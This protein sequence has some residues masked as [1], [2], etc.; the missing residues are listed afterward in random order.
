MDPWSRLT[1]AS[2]AQT[3][4][5]RYYMPCNE[6]SVLSEEHNRMIKRAIHGGRT[7]ARCLLKEWTDEEV[8]AGKYGVYQDVQSLYPTVQF[9]DPL[10]V[11]PPKYRA[12]GPNAQVDFKNF[13]GFACVDI[14]PTKYL[15]HPVL[16]ELKDNK[17]IADLY[18]QYQQVIC[19]PEL[20]VALANGYVVMRVHWT[21]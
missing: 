17:L 6:M 12:Y 2:Y 10:P 1:I 16:V 8:R 13:F 15:H 21:L 7:D 9:Y 11:G 3:M 18:P 20:H 14:R 19:S 4:Y 5:M